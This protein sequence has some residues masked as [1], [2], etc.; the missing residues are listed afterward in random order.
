MS[1]VPTPAVAP[2]FTGWLFGIPPTVRLG[3]DG[4]LILSQSRRHRMLLYVQM[5]LMVA[6]VAILALEPGPTHIKSPP[7]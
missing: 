5:I 4:R 1:D 2:L 6:L 3:D 7:L